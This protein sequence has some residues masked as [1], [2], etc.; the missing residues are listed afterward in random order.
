VAEIKQA[1][2]HL[3]PAELAEVIAFIRDQKKAAWE[4][5][6]EEDFSPGGARYG[7][8]QEIDAQID[9]GEYKPLP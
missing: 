7:L 3:S 8:I 9:A 6:I 2:S 4:A 1:I 5:Q